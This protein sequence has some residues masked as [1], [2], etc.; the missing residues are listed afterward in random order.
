MAQQGVQREQQQTEGLIAVV[1]HGLL[2]S[3][4]VV[5]AGIQTVR[6]RWADLT[7]AERDE[8]LERALAHTTFVAE[9]LK[10][11]SKGLTEGSAT[12]LEELRPRSP[13]CER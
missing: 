9:G 12:E 10:A 6:E 1:A 13:T 7:P 3:M 11:V 8:L 5:S 2:T 4:A